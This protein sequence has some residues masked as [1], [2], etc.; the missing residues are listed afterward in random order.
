MDEIQTPVTVV[1]TSLPPASAVSEKGS[2]WKRLF[3]GRI[4]RLEFIVGVMITVGIYVALYSAI[5]LIIFVKASAKSSGPAFSPIVAII[6]ILMYVFLMIYNFSFYIRRLHDIGK[7]GWYCLLAFIPLV[8]IF[9]GLLVLLKR[10]DESE[11]KYGVAPIGFDLK[12]V[13]AI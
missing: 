7:S 5:F 4:N 2:L 3:G 12:A 1:P 9:I 10:G 11:N 8:N 13:L 6:S